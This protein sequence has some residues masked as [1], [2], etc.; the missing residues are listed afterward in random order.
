MMLA[1][2]IISLNIAVSAVSW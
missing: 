2:V 1:L